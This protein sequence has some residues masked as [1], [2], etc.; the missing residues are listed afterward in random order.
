MTE[1]WIV[2]DEV[3]GMPQAEILR[4]MLEAQ[5]IPSVLSQEGAG[6]AIGLTIGTLGTVQILIPA[7]DLER[8]QEILATFYAG[9]GEDLEQ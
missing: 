8:A 5:E 9:S 3:A 6:R 7:K 2:L 4:G 1:D